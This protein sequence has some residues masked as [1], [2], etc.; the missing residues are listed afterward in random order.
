MLRHLK[1]LCQYTMQIPVRIGIPDVGFAPG[2]YPEL[3]NPMYSTSLG[4]LK[5]GIEGVTD[6]FADTREDIKE[7][8]STKPNKKKPTPKKESF[9]DDILKSINRFL[10]E[11]LEKAT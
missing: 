4:L 10:G 5:F 2:L 1:E 3:K 9:F 11:M 6:N 8:K 7:D